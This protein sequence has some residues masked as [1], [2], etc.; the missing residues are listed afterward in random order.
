MHGTTIAFLS[1][2]ATTVGGLLFYRIINGVPYICSVGTA[3][4]QYNALKVCAPAV[5]IVRKLISAAAN[6]CR[7]GRK[8]SADDFLKGTCT[9]HRQYRAPVVAADKYHVSTKCSLLFLYIPKYLA[10]IW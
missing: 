1:G 2:S 4:I 10:M 8:G 9:Q 6:A 3:Y 5:R 7:Q